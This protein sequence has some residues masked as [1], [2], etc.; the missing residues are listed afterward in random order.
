MQGDKW[1][2]S[3]D[4][5]DAAGDRSSIPEVAVDQQEN[6]AFQFGSQRKG[7]ENRQKFPMRD[8]SSSKVRSIFVPQSSR[9]LLQELRG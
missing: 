5:Q 8:S 6:G 3:D 2:R 7:A 1:L 4:S 9:L